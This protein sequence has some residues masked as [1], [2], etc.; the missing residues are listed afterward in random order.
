MVL[1]GRIDTLNCDTESQLGT[2][3]ALKEIFALYIYLMITLPFL[4]IV[5]VVTPC[6]DCKSKLEGY[7]G[8]WRAPLFISDAKDDFFSQTHLYILLSLGK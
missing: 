2:E 3:T 6:F 1:K 8:D 5:D 7:N 4:Y